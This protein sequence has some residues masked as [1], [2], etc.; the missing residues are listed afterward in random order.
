[1]I[2]HVCLILV[3]TIVVFTFFTCEK[4]VNHKDHT[5]PE[6]SII[7]PAEGDTIR[8]NI[9]IQADAYDESGIDKVEF[10]ID[11]KIFIS[12]DYIEPYNCLVEICYLTYEEEHVIYAKA[13]DNEGNS[14]N[15]QYI[16]IKIE[17][18]IIGSPH[19]IFPENECMFEKKFVREYELYLIWNKVN[20]ASHYQLIMSKDE[21]FN[22]LYTSMSI[23][24]TV[25][26]LNDTFDD[27]T[28]YWFVQALDENNNLISYSSI[29]QVD[30]IPGLIFRRCYTDIAHSAIQIDD[31]GYVAVGRWDYDFWIV[32]LSN[33]GEVIWNRTFGES[34][35]SEAYS[36]IQ[37]EDGCYVIAGFTYEYKQSP[38]NAWIVKIDPAGNLLWERQFGANFSATGRN[39]KETIDNGYI[40]TGWIEYDDSTNTDLWLVKTDI[41]GN[42]EWDITFGGSGDDYGNSVLQLEDGSFIVC[43]KTYSYGVQGSDFL[44]VKFDEFGNC[45]WYRTYGS[46]DYEYANSV[47]KGINGGYIVAGTSQH[48][49]RGIGRDIIVLK[50]DDAGFF[51]WECIYSLGYYNYGNDIT[52]T[53]DQGYLIAGRANFSVAHSHNL[54]LIKIDIDG[55]QLWYKDYGD[56]RGFD[57]AN[58]IMP[59][60]DGG[61]I[62]AGVTGSYSH[63]EGHQDCWIMKVD[64]N[65][66][67]K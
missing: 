14:S 51:E 39:I 17:P 32:R 19:L 4:V 6:V 66:Y 27:V 11:N 54:L 58:S 30:I 64:E 24:D 21:Y 9:T 8:E 55:N 49:Y 3:F 26:V 65:G 42:Q 62:I 46:E 56:E 48:N 23:E 20:E 31:G 1:M 67:A 35:W 41:N 57:E 61:Y 16:S 28:Y 63:H 45:L 44:I 13:Y 12:E 52:N 47:I 60:S 25:F 7:Y 50:I 18:L 34:G 33:I 36:L 37:S 40:V 29:Q 22:D 10:Y 53:N 38:K 5:S 2:K 15:S 59:T 43:G